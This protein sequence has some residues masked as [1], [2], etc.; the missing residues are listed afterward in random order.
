MSSGR[1]SGKR[2]IIKGAGMGI[3]QA[4]ALRFAREGA[5]VGLIY[6][7]PCLGRGVLCDG[8]SLGLRWRHDGYPS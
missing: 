5:R 8:C 3:G 1:I 2:A 7:L 6:A 4:T